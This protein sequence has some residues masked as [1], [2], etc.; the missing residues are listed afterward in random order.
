MA[1]IRW[2]KSPAELIA[3]ARQID[4]NFKAGLENRGQ[5]WSAELENRAKQQRP[6]TDRTNK[7]RLGLKGRYVMDNVTLTI[8]LIHTVKYGLY[9]E[10]GTKNMDP[11]AVIL[12][13]LEEAYSD[14]MNDMKTLWEA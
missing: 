10:L 2:T 5:Y 6:W 12:P 7:A 9:L 14:I 8:Y 3:A 13:V 11:Y 4:D 1:Y